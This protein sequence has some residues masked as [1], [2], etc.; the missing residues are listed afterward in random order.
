MNGLIEISQWNTEF[1]QNLISIPQSY[2]TEFNQIKDGLEKAS[3]LLI[4][5]HLYLCF[6]S[7]NRSS[8]QEVFKALPINHTA[9][10]MPLQGKMI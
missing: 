9:T 1:L 2:S 5:L 3:V 7:L 4:K 8:D 10:K 6:H